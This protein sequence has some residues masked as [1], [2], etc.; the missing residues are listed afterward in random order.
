[1]KTTTRLAYL[2][3]T[4]KQDG[5]L[6]LKRAYSYA[7]SSAFSFDI[8][9]NISTSTRKTINYVIEEARLASQFLG[10]Y[11]VRSHTDNRLLVMGQ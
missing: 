11:H 1:M 9:M 7:Y 10:D 2:F 5:G 4:L 3:D 6:T 8:N